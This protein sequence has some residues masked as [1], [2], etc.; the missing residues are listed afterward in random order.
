[1]TEVKISEVLHLAADK[2]LAEDVGY[3]LDLQDEHSCLA[4][5][6]AIRELVP[7]ELKIGSLY[8]RI[9][10]GLEEMG[11]NTRRGSQF[12][13]FC[14]ED[15][16]VVYDYLSINKASQG[17]RYNWLKFAAMIAEEQGV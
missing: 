7:A 3:D 13:E 2:Y 14:V 15:S 10:L 6:S 9:C 11:L 17:A 1:M 16:E 5:I 12:D 8:I 4:I